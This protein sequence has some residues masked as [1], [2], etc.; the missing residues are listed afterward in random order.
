MFRSADNLQ[1]A[2]LFVRIKLNCVSITLQMGLKYLTD[3][4][5]M[6]DKILFTSHTVC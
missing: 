1:V 4:I 2:L 6:K 3:K 5:I